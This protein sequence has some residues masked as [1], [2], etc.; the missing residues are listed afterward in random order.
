MGPSGS[1]KTTLL[2]IMGSRAQ[3]YMACMLSLLVERLFTHALGICPVILPMRLQKADLAIFYEYW[4][5]F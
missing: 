1:G 4:K 2:S 3:R 5:L